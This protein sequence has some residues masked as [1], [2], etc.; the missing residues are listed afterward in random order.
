MDAQFLDAALEG[1]ISADEKLSETLDACA[2]HAE[3]LGCREEL[4][5]ARELSRNPGAE[6]QRGQARKTP[7]L[8]GLVAALADAF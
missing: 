2:Q 6:R 1:Q 8:T 5:G 7:G 4:E 3:E